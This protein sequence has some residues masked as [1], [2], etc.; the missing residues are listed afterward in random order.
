MA[1]TGALMILSGGWIA[2]EAFGWEA[3]AAFAIEEAAETAI[4]QTT[5]LPIPIINDPFDI[6]QEGAE[7]LVKESAEESTERIIKEVELN[8][9]V[10]EVIGDSYKP[11]ASR[12]NTIK[13][14]EVLEV[15]NKKEPGEWAKI[16]EAGYLKGE[17]VEVHYFVNKKTKNVFD[18][19]LKKEGNWSNTNFGKKAGSNKI[20]END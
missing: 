6:V 13:N 9:S 18:V 3:V 7:K 17:K 5:G 19:K 8:K 20:I 11:I 16:Y 2:V 14:Q 15:L 12:S 1:A 10:K 4:E